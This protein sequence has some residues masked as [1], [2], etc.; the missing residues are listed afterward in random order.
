MTHRPPPPF[1]SRKERGCYKGG[2]ADG[3]PPAVKKP[4]RGRT[5]TQVN[6]ILVLDS[7][8]TQNHGHRCREVRGIVRP[9]DSGNASR[10]QLLVVDHDVSA[11]VA[12]HL[13]HRRSERL[14]L[15]INHSI[16]PSEVA[17]CLVR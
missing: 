14:A 3:V 17:C 13:L 4:F 12:I 16:S 5:P 9:K 10:C 6:A 2:T 15:E 7:M 1:A 8:G 11:I